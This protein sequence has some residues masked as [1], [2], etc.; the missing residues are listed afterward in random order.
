MGYIVVDNLDDAVIARLQDL[1]RARH[2]SLEQVAHELL[3]E[4]ARPQKPDK[5]ELL[6]RMDRIRAMSPASDIDSVPLIRAD[7]D[8]LRCCGMRET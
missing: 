6:A 1:A 4:A 7:R 3:T 5:G 8:A 2:K